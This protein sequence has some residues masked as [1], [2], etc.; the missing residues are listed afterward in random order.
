[1]NQ[2][3]IGYY[4][5]VSPKIPWVEI[6]LAQLQNLPFEGFEFSEKG[7]NAFILKSEHFEN[8]LDSIELFHNDKVKIE[9]ELETIMP[10]N[11]NSKWEKTFKPI[12]ISSECVIRADFHKKFGKKYEI[13]I[14]PKM[15]F[16]TGHHETTMMMIEY[17]LEISFIK[18]KVL[19]MGCGTGILAIIASKK[20]ACSISAI[21]KDPC[22]V[23][24]TI[25]NSRKNSCNNI[26][27]TLTEKVNKEHGVYDL[28]FANINLN[29]L[30]NQIPFFAKVLKS[31]GDLLLSGFFYQD[32]TN[33]KEKCEDFG[34]KIINNK[35]KNDWCA[36]RFKKH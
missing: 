25:E 15:S 24:N 20:K 21:D 2:N 3:Y 31:N 35:I 29:E 18:K 8:F 36:I 4:F 14:N 19:D 6:L 11:W 22:C 9:Y 10:S 23:E 28:I 34:F 26:N 33:L 17:A 7:L 32:L 13:I 1:M 27:V 16:G 5:K 30:L 12:H